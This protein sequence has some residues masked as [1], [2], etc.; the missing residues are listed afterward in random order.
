MIE[1]SI[2]VRFKNNTRI[3]DIQ[4][5]PTVKY[6]HGSL[7]PMVN[8]LNLKNFFPFIGLVNNSTK[9]SDVLYHLMLSSA[10]LIQ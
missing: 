3:V 7:C 9:I 10:Y 6:D 4:H 2:F 5:T 1:V 8:I